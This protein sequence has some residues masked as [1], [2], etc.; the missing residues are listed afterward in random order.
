MARNARSRNPFD[1][2]ARRQ[3]GLL[4]LA[5]IGF[6]V[7]L[8]LALSWAA[9]L[10]GSGERAARAVDPATRTV[11]AVLREEPPQLNSMLATDQIS[12]MVLGHVMEGLLRYD[13]QGHL[14]AGVAEHW[15]QQD[16]TI[17][18]R[19][20]ADARWS[21]GR[22]V[23]AHDFVF[24]WRT[25]LDP[26]NAS[27]YAFILFPIL[28]ATAINQGSLPV[29]ELGA[30]AVD[31]RTLT[32]QL[33]RPTAYFDKLVAF[34]T[35][36]PVRQDFYEATAARYG[37]DAHTLLYN[38]PFVISRWI[39]GAQ[40][41]LEQNPHYWDRANIQLDVIDFPYMTDD[42]NTVVNLFKDGQV[43]F[44]NLSEQSLGDALR[45]RW[46]IRRFM[47][48]SVYFMD[49]NHR[50]ERVTRN[51]NLRLAI[52][53]SLDADELVN[54]V[55]K[56]PGYL[57]ARSIFPVWLPGVERAFREEFPAPVRPR[58]PEGAR[59]HLALALQELGLERLPPLMLLTSD[60][61]VSGKQAE[62]YQAVLR[63]TLGI[64]IRIDKQIF[65]QRLAK[66]SAGEFDLVLAGWGPD[67]ADP[68]TFGDLFSSWNLNN[69]G[70][71]ASA[72]V[73]HQ[74]RIAQDSLDP[75]TRMAAFGAIQQILFDDVTVLPEYE[76]GAV[77]VVDPRLQGLVRRVVGPDPDFTRAWIEEG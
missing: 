66:M 64:E 70:R 53:L 21:D 3:L 52:A 32:V 67:F 30:T 45:E 2:A 19:L 69:R 55:I 28:N 36:Y 14:V 25:A 4:G 61:P 23:T 7:A 39:H 51:R 65:K 44:A 33:E 50:P 6:F 43:A 16:L 10:T 47:D 9:G 5:A 73:D 40:L 42:P 22:P 60:T 71:Y 1:R 41:R 15:S 20:R 27:E 48:G 57:P 77:Y 58:D 29:T 74:V 75:A 37:A 62:Y 12:G 13:A 54:K 18:F 63:D 11:T 56:L 68:L 72:A 35:Y 17:T 59:R 49:F 8:M 76:R 26:A 34:T 31:D 38:G 46:H 24:A